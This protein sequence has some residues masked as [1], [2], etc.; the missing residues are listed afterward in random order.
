[1]PMPMQMPMPMPIPNYESRGECAHASVEDNATKDDDRHMQEALRQSGMEACAASAEAATKSMQASAA[2]MQASAASMQACA[3]SAERATM[4]ACQA[5]SDSKKA[6][7]HSA[8]VASMIQE[9]F[10]E[11]VRAV[12]MDSFSK[13]YEACN[14]DR[15][16]KGKDK[17]D[18]ANDD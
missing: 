1:M 8:K 7:G 2:S 14:K 13:G 17:D 11:H 10:D 18:G 9:H 12:R 16:D 15:G 6:A 5:S 3:E 4:G